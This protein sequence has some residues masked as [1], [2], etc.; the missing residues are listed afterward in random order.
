MRALKPYLKGLALIA[1]LVAIAYLVQASGLYGLLDEAWVD[2]EIRGRGLAGELLF[3]GVGAALTA[4][5]FPRQAVAFFGGYAFGLGLG[6]GLA[7]T[8]AAGGCLLAFGYARLLGRAALRARF[9][10]RIRRLDAFLR[11]NT[12]STTV[13]IRLLP[14]GSNL[15]TNLAAGVSGVRPGPF[16]AGS[17]LGYLPQTAI[18]ALLGSGLKIEPELRIAASAA[19][20]VL[21]GMIGLWLFR[22]YRRAC[23]APAPFDGIEEAA[24][25]RAP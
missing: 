22:R 14:V 7:V 25:E 24:G 4:V 18:F 5:G 2:R 6:T 13:L 16:V 12:F 17:A 9:P 3:L 8:A 20:F 10:E 1:S 21:S 19:L 23:G 15:V 11:D